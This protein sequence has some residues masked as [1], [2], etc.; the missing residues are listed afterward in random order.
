MGTAKDRQLGQTAIDKMALLF[1][2]VDQMKWHQVKS[3]CVL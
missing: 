1:Q 2:Q 3:C